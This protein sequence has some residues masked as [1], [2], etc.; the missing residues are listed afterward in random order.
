[1]ASKQAMNTMNTM[2]LN[3]FLRNVKT[4]DFKAH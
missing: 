2:K 3:M 1:M 4:M